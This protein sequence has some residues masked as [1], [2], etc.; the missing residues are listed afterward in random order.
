MED[1][2]IL[3]IAGPT[4]VGKTDLS[5]KLAKIF[6]GEIINADSM[7]I[8][9][10]MD[11]GTGKPTLQERKHIPH[12][13]FDVAKPCETFNVVTYQS[14]ALNIIEKILERGHLPIVVGGTGLYISAL[15]YDVKFETAPSNELT[16]KK[17]NEMIDEKGLDKIYNMLKKCDSYAA[18]F[19]N[20][21]DRIRI[22]RALEL[23]QNALTTKR[24]KRADWC[25]QMRC[26]IGKY[27]VKSNLFV[28]NCEPRE[29]LYSR[30]ND[31]VDAMMKDGLLQ[32]VELL[33]QK[34]MG[35]TARQAIGYKEFF[36]L[37]NGESVNCKEVVDA[38]KQNTRH[39]AKR[40]LTWFRQMK[41]AN[42]ISTEDSMKRIIEQLQIKSSY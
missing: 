32:E 34:G 2:K 38:I 10:G 31:R 12:H 26:Y 20:K 33:Y 6:N 36:P 40:Q 39:Y 22:V 8:Y 14:M 27:K 17:I 30:I 9:C 11:I 5:L 18:N 19:I 21:N 28:L 25:K 3:F 37:I 7:Q 35:Q 13:M 1:R 42:W 4:A 29:R 23:Q 15:F 24:E 16:R 41:E